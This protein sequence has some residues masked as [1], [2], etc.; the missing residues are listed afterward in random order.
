MSNE[1]LRSNWRTKHGQAKKWKQLVFIAVSKHIPDKP[2]MK[3]K[4]TLTRFSAKRPDFDG[5]VAGFKPV[6]D[7]LVEAGVITNDDFSV[8]GVPEY[9]HEIMPPKKGKIKIKV[10]EL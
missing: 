5:L 7:G 4:L 9:L 2:F 6:I 3:A 10:E 8:V 1:L